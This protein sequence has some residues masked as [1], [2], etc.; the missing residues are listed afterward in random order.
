MKSWENSKKLTPLSLKQ[1]SKNIILCLQDHW[2]SQCQ[3]LLWNSHW[4]FTVLSLQSLSEILLY[5]IFWKQSDLLPM[6]IFFKLHCINEVLHRVL[7]ALYIAFILWN[8]F[9]N[10]AYLSTFLPTSKLGWSG[11]Q[12][13]LNTIVSKTMESL[14]K[15]I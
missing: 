12:L 7:S 15:K 4:S 9:I 8:H 5:F 11:I 6:G 3:F 1:S 13:F 10:A 2:I 14:P